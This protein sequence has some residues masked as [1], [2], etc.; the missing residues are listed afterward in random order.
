MSMGYEIISMF[1]E[2]DFCL[3]KSKFKFKSDLKR[4][5][6][7]KIPEEDPSSANC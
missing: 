4:L 1:K 2:N 6:I 3:G 5:R 7:P